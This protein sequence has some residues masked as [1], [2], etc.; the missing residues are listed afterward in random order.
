[1]R[2]AFQHAGM[3][4]P[5]TPRKLS[6]HPPPCRAGGGCRQFTGVWA[7]PIGWVGGK[8]AEKILGA[9]IGEAFCHPYTR[10]RTLRDFQ[11]H[12]PSWLASEIARPSQESYF[13]ATNEMDRRTR[14]KNTAAINMHEMQIGHPISFPVH[15]FHVPT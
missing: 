1:V 3:A 2:P 5:H 12:W 7:K 14:D 9:A 4:G 8:G 6:A 13:V 10:Q 11:N 15:V